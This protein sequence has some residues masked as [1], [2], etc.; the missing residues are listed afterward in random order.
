MPQIPATLQ[1]QP[2]QPMQSMQPQQGGSFW[3][4]LY[5]FL[6]G[7]PAGYQMLQN[8]TPEQ[9]QGFSALL[10]QGLNQYQ[11]PYQGFEGLQQEAL[12]QY[13]ED[14]LPALGE[15]FGA[16]RSRLSSPTFASQLGSSAAA[17]NSMLNAQKADYGMRNRQQGLQAAALG[18]TPQFNYQGVAGSSGL[19]GG[20]INA[21]KEL[22]PVAAQGGLMYATGGLSGAPGIASLIG[23]YRGGK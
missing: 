3:N 15:K 18:L 12:R 16:S 14:F 4:S 23:K 13:N 22:A 2:M 21:L 6:F 1:Q 5:E 11:N 17:F 7:T 19:I 9:Q 8:F 20:G 10:Q